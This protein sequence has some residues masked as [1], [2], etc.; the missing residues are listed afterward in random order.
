MNNKSKK[1]IAICAYGKV[2]KKLSNFI[3]NQSNYI[4]S[5]KFVCTLNKDSYQK[6]IEEIYNKT[7]IKVFNNINVNSRIFRKSM[8]ENKIDIVF[9]LWWPTIVK[10]SSI[11]MAKI[12][13]VNLHPSLLPFNRGMHPYY[14]SIVENTPAGVSIHFI[15][16]HIDE[17]K[18]IYQKEIKKNITMT[19]EILYEM[20]QFEI[21][22]LFEENYVNIIKGVYNT[23][24]VKNNE[25]TFHY[26]KELNLHSKID[27]EKEYKAIDLI[28]LIRGRSFNDNPSSFFIHKG[29]KYYINIKITPE[30]ED[31]S[32]KKN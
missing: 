14:W 8:L 5:V 2:G 27:L 19:G 16:K 21:I 24:E 10:E 23:K 18:I 26:K 12:G 25:G 20:A 15:N 22:K 1:N 4:D 17:G 3:A 7:N 13:F 30:K 29:K 9:L 11:D 32:S 31:E 6:E 28:N